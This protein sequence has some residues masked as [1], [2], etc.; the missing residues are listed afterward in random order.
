MFIA[1]WENARQDRKFDISHVDMLLYID[2][3]DE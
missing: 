2:I 1:K 3:I